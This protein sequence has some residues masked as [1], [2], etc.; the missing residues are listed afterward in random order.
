MAAEGNGKAANGSSP[1][2]NGKSY[3]IEDHT[4]DVVV[5]GAGGAG[6]R[7]GV[8]CAEAGLRT[9]CITT[10]FPTHSHTGAA[11]AAG[12]APASP[13]C[14]RRPGAGWGRKGASAP[15]SATWART[16]GA[17]TC[18]TPSRAP[19][20]SATRKRSKTRA[21]APPRRGA[22]ADPRAL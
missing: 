4:Y 18:T 20:G 12:A 1:A 6:L 19:T 8:G 17:G 13:S 16:T 9:A 15:R 7:A 22:H 14:S 3:P 5:V 21:P 2:T 10:G 11:Q